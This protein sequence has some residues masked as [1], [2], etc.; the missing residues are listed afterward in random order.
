MNKKKSTEDLLEEISKKLDKLILISAIQGKDIDTQIIIL[1][2]QGLEWNDIGNLLGI[3]S[4]AAR[5]RYT[6]MK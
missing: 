6:R 2:N 5:M 4:D 1:R 3:K